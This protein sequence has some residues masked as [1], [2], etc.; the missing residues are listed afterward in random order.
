MDCAGVWGGNAQLDV[1]GVCSGDGITGYCSA[2]EGNSE[3]CNEITRLYLNGI[4]SLEETEQGCNG[5]SS[6]E[7]IDYCDCDANVCDCSNPNCDAEDE[8]CGGTAVEEIY[9]FDGDSDGEGAGPIGNGTYY[10]NSDVTSEFVQ[11]YSDADDDCTS[12]EYQDWY[13]DADGDGLGSGLTVS[14]LCTDDSVD[15]SVTNSDDADD[16]CVTNDR[17]Y[18]GVCAGG[19][20]D[21]LG[22]GCFEPAA[23]SYWVD[24]D[25]DGLGAGDSTDYCL[26]EASGVLNGDDN[27]DACFSNEYQDWFVDGDSDG[28]GAGDATNLCTDT[29]EVAGS[30]TNSSDDDDA[31]FSNEYQDWF[32]DGDSDGFGGELTNDDLCT[33][34]DSVEGSVIYG[35]NSW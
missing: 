14:G 11:N 24:L 9:W 13:L 4:S 27:D 8:E 22:C 26:P 32:V 16:D 25:G 19:G 15:G 12:N 20:A 6:C 5:M 31:C 18:C 10:C 34:I 1:C 33:D 35:D 30:V 3:W 17:D 2:K 23:L 28:L 21:D 29:T 7:W